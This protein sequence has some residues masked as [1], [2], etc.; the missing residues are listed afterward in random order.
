VCARSR[1]HASAP[2]TTSAP[3]PAPAPPSWFDGGYA[4]DMKDSIVALLNASQPDA[5]AFG[6]LG[7]S[8]NPICWIGTESGAPGGDIWSTGGNGL[9]DPNSPTVCPKACDTTLQDGDHWFFTAGDAIRTRAQ[10]IE[11]YHGTVGRNGVLE[12]DFAINRDGL[13]EPAHAARY[14]ELGDWARSC[15]GAPRWELAN[16]TCAAQQCVLELE[17]D[18]AGAAVDRV[19]IRE[20]IGLGQRVRAY[21]VQAMALGSTAWQAFSSGKA[22]GN[23]RIDLTK[24]PVVAT[25]LRLTVSAFA[26]ADALLVK[27]FAAFT[28]VGCS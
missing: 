28:P 10:L 19:M 26:G 17:L 21:T 13:V 20:E 3:P 25:K 22:V 9:G 4:S 16:A 24:E 14:K 2:L 18:P 7:V 27:Q 1:C 5:A 8:P 6:G 11:V 23:K 15:Y 12:L